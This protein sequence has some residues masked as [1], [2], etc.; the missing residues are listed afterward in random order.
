MPKILRSRIPKPTSGAKALTQPF[1]KTYQKSRIMAAAAAHPVPPPPPPPLKHVCPIC[2]FVAASALDLE[3]HIRLHR[4]LTTMMC[5][6]K[7]YSEELDCQV[8]CTTIADMTKHLRAE[9]M[10]PLQST[11]RSFRF[12]CPY[13][14]D[15]MQNVTD[16]SRHRCF[17]HAEGLFR[18]VICRMTFQ[19]DLIP[20]ETQRYLK[21]P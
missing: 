17:M 2:D 4:G 1:A 8:V 16:Y 3:A 18:C 11:R 19:D 13:C 21:A 14:Y 15:C 5:P 12:L 10:S 6:F 9:H 20:S 7:E